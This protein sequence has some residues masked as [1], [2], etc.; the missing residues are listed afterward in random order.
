M[1]FCYFHIERRCG[2]GGNHFLFP[3]LF[4]ANQTLT[5]VLP[6]DSTDLFSNSNST[7]LEGTDNGSC[8]HGTDWSDANLSVTACNIVL[9]CLHILIQ[10]IEAVVQTAASSLKM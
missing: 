2:W 7:V 10:A 9:C 6:D 3:N 5:Q 4:P 1:V 8:Q